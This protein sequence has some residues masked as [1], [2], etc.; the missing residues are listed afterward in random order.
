MKPD[1]KMYDSIRKS[2]VSIVKSDAGI[3]KKMET[4]CKI[5]KNDFENFEWIGFY[6]INPERKNTL[7][8]GPFSGESTTLTKIRFGEGILGQA[9][10]NE[11]TIIVHDMS[12]EAK[13]LTRNFKVRSE[14]V[15]PILKNDRFKGELKIDSYTKNCFS[16][17]VKEFLKE[18]CDTISVIF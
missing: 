6:L 7:L 13:F 2:I 1:K 4:V 17:N 9:A 11:K 10:E 3:N 18:I 12:K 5:L 15:I 14:I 8:L 16:K